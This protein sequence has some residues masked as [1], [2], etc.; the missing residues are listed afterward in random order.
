MG[1]RVLSSATN[2]NIAVLD[3]ENALESIVESSAEGNYLGDIWPRNA[4]TVGWTS[5]ANLDYKGLLADMR[6]DVANVR[7][8]TTIFRGYP[9]ILK[10]ILS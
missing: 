8:N 7:S 9:L 5:V 6:K 10:K 3:I 2:C 1:R 4:E